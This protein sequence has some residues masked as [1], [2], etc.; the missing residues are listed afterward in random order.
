MP[1]AGPLSQ[2]VEVPLPDAREETAAAATGSTLMVAGGFD[3]AGR[4]RAEVF[5][6]TE[7]AWKLGPRLPRGIDHA[8]AAAIGDTLFIAGGFS[9][10]VAQAAVE[11]LAPG[12]AAWT[13][14]PP[15]AHPRGALALLPLA[16]RLYAI[17]GKVGTGA[18]VSA[19]ESWAPGE[20]LWT[21]LTPLPAPRDHVAGFVGAG[22]LCIAG[23]RSPTTARVDCLGVAGA[24]EPAPALPAP[25]SGAAA[26]TVGTVTIVA[27]GEDA[28]ET[29]LT[30]QVDTLAGPAWTTMPM[31]DPR[32]G[33]EAALFRGRLWLCGGGTAPGLHPIATCT[34]VGPG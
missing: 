32:H 20:A 9:A 1:A 25:T 6:L 33:M 18:E 31:L 7:G 3:T 11:S 27:G 22:R 4:D 34:S 28:A 30:G 10:G 12:G 17:G 24:W 5:L 26:G 16:G 21:E 29:R 2:R 13:P 15:L 14:L 23:G 8:S 19:V